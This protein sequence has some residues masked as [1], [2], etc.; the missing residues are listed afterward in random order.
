[1]IT[2]T[3]SIG[4]GQWKYWTCTLNPNIV[5]IIIYLL[6]YFYD[7]RNTKYAYDV[8]IRSHDPNFKKTFLNH[9][10]CHLGRHRFWG[11]G[12]LTSNIKDIIP[13]PFV[14]VDET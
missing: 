1:M 13:N 3:I 8:F 9:R 6:G 4:S 12:K 14:Q 7:E 11:E 10:Y 2:L 5:I